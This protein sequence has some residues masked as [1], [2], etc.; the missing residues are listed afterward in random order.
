MTERFLPWIGAVLEANV[1]ASHAF[2]AGLLTS[3]AGGSLL[4]TWRSRLCQSSVRL[5]A[6]VSRLTLQMSQPTILTSSDISKDTAAS[7]RLMMSYQPVLVLGVLEEAD[8][9]RSKHWP[10][11]HVHSKQEGPRSG[12]ITSSATEKTRTRLT[13]AKGE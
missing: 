7:G 11:N 2:Y 1:I 4:V 10:A 5:R 13:W 8:I 9:S 6:R 12:H 3:R